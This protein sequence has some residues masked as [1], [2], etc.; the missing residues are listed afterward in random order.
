MSNMLIAVILAALFF[1]YTNGF[2]DAANAIATS[3]STRALSPGGALLLAGSLDFVGALLSTTVA[4]TLAKGIVDP[5]VVTLP[6]ILAGLVAAIVWNLITWYFGIPSSS[7]HCLVG[8]MAGAVAAGY[9]AAGVKWMGIAKKVLIPTVASPLLGFIGGG[10]LTVVLVWIFRRSHPGRMSRRF[11]VLQIFSASAMALSHGVNDAQKTM[12][13]ITLALVAGGVI[14]TADV[15]TWVKL[16]CALVMALGTF[17]GGKRIIKTMGMRLVRLT[18]MDGFAAQAAASAVLQ[19]A[20]HFGF[21]VS[22][23][24]A[25]TASVM[26]VGATHRVKAVR[27][28]VTRKIVTAWVL[29][30][31]AAG[32]LGAGLALALMRIN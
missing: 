9:G 10:L 25:I 7:S 19:S 3:I 28:G 20:A 2:H 31:P 5:A 12:G 32:I 18:P 17:S 21:P 30:L 8:G 4:A 23:T 13:V 22:T 27:W 14:P 1:E 15:P 6:I 29:T 16:T 11:R 24:H 26:G